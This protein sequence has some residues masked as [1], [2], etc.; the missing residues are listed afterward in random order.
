[1]A[2][3]LIFL[4]VLIRKGQSKVLLLRSTP[5]VEYSLHGERRERERGERRERRETVEGGE[6]RKTDVM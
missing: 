3:S 1:M 5:F 6:R 4:G 2:P